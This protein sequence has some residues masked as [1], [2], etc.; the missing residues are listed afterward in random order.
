MKTT[1]PALWLLKTPKGNTG[2]KHVDLKTHFIKDVVM[3]SVWKVYSLDKKKFLR[4]NWTWP[5]SENTFRWTR[6][7]T[8]LC[9]RHLWLS[10]FQGLGFFHHYFEI[11]ANPD[12]R[13][14]GPCGNSSRIG[15]SSAFLH[16]RY[17]WELS[18]QG[19]GLICQVFEVVQTPRGRTWSP[20]EN[21][22]R[23]SRSSGPH[24]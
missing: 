9:R 21:T 19:L 2:I 12:G 13:T 8:P 1:R 17:H 18:C 7:N 20:G 10:S 23:N 14:S 6:S 22:F 16:Y 24:Y 4:V 3:D 15:R 11:S 5:G